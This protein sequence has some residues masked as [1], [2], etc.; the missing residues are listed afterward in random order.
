MLATAGTCRSQPQQVGPEE[1]NLHP[2]GQQQICSFQTHCG[3]QALVSPVGV[4]A[5]WASYG[6]GK[7][8]A[9]TGGSR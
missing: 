7:G 2:K 4:Q 1:G 6:G 3:L 8:D 5:V 9:G